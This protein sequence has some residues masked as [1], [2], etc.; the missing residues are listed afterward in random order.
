M[1]EQKKNRK[2]EIPS[3]RRKKKPPTTESKPKN[4]KARTRE[5]AKLVDARRRDF[6]KRPFDGID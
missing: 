1:R 5:G 6:Q 2:R 4:Q 3:S